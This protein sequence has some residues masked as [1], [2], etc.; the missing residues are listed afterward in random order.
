[1][2]LHSQ[3]RRIQESEETT[4]WEELP[5]AKYE[6]WKRKKATERDWIQYLNCTRRVNPTKEAE[7][8][9]FISLWR[10]QE[11][12]DLA[13]TLALAQEAEDVI[14]TNLSTCLLLKIIADGDYFS[15]LDGPGL[16]FSLKKCITSLGQANLQKVREMLR[17]FSLLKVDE[18]TAN[19]IQVSFL[20][21]CI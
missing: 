6:Q 7:V 17:S 9:T 5:I 18:V 16:F 19:V 4:K 13:A 10:D 21:T 14:E 20:N 3:G 15:F 12:L 11:H 2:L 1:M 8:N